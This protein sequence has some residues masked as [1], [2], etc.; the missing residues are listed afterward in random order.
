MLVNNT[1]H[2]LL[3]IISLCRAVSKKSIRHR[4][5]IIT[6]ISIFE[7]RILETNHPTQATNMNASQFKRPVDELQQERMKK[8]RFNVEGN[9]FF[10]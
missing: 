1:Q 9:P 3:Y 7:L 2:T 10:K 4:T 8:Q 5:E 6:R